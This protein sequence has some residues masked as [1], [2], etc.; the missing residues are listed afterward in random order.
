ML[1]DTET[2]DHYLIYIYVRIHAA[3]QWQPPKR[4]A[5]RT[6]QTQLPLNGLIHELTRTHTQSAT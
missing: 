4:N 5:Y 6:L 2:Q 1:T 3:R